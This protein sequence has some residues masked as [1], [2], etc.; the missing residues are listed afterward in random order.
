MLNSWQEAEEY[1]RADGF[2]WERDNSVLAMRLRH[3]TD[4][5][6]VARGYPK[7]P[8]AAIA[9]MRSR[10]H[11][12]GVRKEGWIVDLECFEGACALLQLHHERWFRTKR[13]ALAFAAR[14]RRI[15]RECAAPGG[16]GR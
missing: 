6:W 5:V 2:T 13:E 10:Q 9:V 15:G 4:H 12:N 11:P 3:V 16:V 14:L 7:R 1:L 8:S